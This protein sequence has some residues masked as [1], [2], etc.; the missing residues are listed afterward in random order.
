MTGRRDNLANVHGTGAAKK[1]GQEFTTT[2]I[3]DFAVFESGHD[4]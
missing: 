4:N 2:F 3:L 1:R